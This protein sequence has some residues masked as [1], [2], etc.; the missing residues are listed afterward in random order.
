M[1]KIT[2]MLIVALM[3]V[4]PALT[5]KARGE[6]QPQDQNGVTAKANRTSGHDR[7]RI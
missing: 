2:A 6:S 7:G 1:T 3:V 4:N 5:S